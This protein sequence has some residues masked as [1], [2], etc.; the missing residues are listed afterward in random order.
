MEH[1]VGTGK[2]DRESLKEKDFKGYEKLKEKAQKGL[3]NR[4]SLLEKIDLKNKSLD[5]LKNTSTVVESMEDLKRVLDESDLTDV[6]KIPSEFESKIGGGMDQDWQ[7]S[8]AAE[9]IDLFTDY[10]KVDFD[11]VKKATAWYNRY[12]QTYHVENIKW[13]GQAII[14]SCSTEL[15]SKL[16]QDTRDLP[17]RM[18][19]G[20]TYLYLVI[21]KIIATSETALRGLINK[22][23][24][25]KLTDYDGENV[26][27]CVT[28]IRNGIK[29]MKDHS[30]IPHD[31]KSIVLEVFSS[32]TCERFGAVVSAL[33]SDVDLKR[34]QIDV[35]EILKLL[36]RNY[37][38]KLGSGEW[39]AKDSSTNEG[40]TFMMTMDNMM[41]L[42]CG[43]F[44]HKV[45]DCPEP[46]NEEA[47]AKRKKLLFKSKEGNQTGNGK[48]RKSKDRGNSGSEKNRDPKRQPPKNG[49]EHEKT[50]D[51]K[52][53]NWC[54]KCGK[55][56]N[57]STKE[58]RPKKKDNEKA[59]EES[60]KDEEQANAII[61]GATALH[62]G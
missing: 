28:Y 3:P 57:H 48:G 5:Q 12:G 50:F 7:P 60:K 2:K 40:S 20:P 9:E 19:G 36:E 61:G 32:N 51:G 26:L 15:R 14:N 1:S 8:S 17:E 25:M 39:T 58:H 22:I 59:D 55:W 44:G 54:G 23:S 37:Q 21:E 34:N 46:I 47:I 42:N 33:R 4:F 27:D 11:I 29:V 62:F 24:S 35:D 13:S 10:K 31:I 16:L 52:K 18:K 53:L 49:E 6:F 30:S 45:K 41:C 38:D 43:K 56:T